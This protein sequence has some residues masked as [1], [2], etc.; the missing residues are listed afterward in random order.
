MMR[1]GRKNKFQWAVALVLAMAV[2]GVCFAGG[3]PSE[4]AAEKSTDRPDQARVTFTEHIAPIIFNNCTDCHREGQVAP[5][6][7]EDYRD[8]QKRAQMIRDVVE[9]RLM[10]PWPPARDHVEFLGERHLSDEQ[11]DMIDQW[12]EGGM[13]E[14]DPEKLPAMPKFKD[15]W[16][17]GEPD[18]ILEMDRPFRVPADGPDIYRN[19]VLKTPKFEDTAY[20]R[21]IEVYPSSPQVIHHV[22][23]FLDSSGRS[24]E[25]DARDE[26]PGFS[27]MA[28]PAT[29][30]LDNAYAAGSQSYFLP[31]DYANY[32]P[33]NT[34]IVMQVHFYPSGKEVM[35]KTRL[36]LHLT[37]K[38]PSRK[39]NLWMIPPW[40]SMFAG[41]DIPPGEKNYTLEETLPVPV[42]LELVSIGG[43]AHY[44][45]TH[46][47]AWARLPDGTTK[48]L[49]YL[50]RWDLDWQ[51][52]YMFKEK[53]IVPKGSFIDVKLVYDNSS[54]NP[55]NPFNPPQR[56]TFGLELEDEMGFF[57]FTAVPVHEED[58]DTVAAMVDA[59]NGYGRLIQSLRGQDRDG[60]GKIAEEEAD[61]RLK[62]S[63]GRFDANDDGVMDE[64]EMKKA[65]LIIAGFP[66]YE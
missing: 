43:H 9:M 45:A 21:A 14:G 12:I 17:L 1:L 3:G 19:F 57:S 41:I 29:G 18:L 50:P 26:P 28:V 44:L 36:G 51:G 66:G 15:G 23:L 59:W 56:V 27:G 61:E 32:L 46:M 30:Y 31:K 16:K 8:V 48:D 40:F 55:S 33:P 60:D 11:I 5:F 34:D 20:I 35:E 65:A 22:L 47:K 58:A 2:S 4:S 42:D 37:D 54:D 49:L 39:I 62:V 13:P 52:R 6:P 63:F 53:T 7:L 24:R 38:K 64:D 25:F 10:P